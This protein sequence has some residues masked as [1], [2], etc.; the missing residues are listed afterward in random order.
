VI[1][2]Q[3]A[4]VKVI[5]TGFSIDF[6]KK[7]F[8]TITAKATLSSPIPTDKEG[9][10]EVIIPVQLVNR[11][12]VVVAKAIAKWSVLVRNKKSK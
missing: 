7:A 1:T 5:L 9:S 2:A 8:G 10:H 3:Q 11:E 4:G 12:G 6:L